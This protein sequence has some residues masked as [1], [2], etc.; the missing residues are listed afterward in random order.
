[1][2]RPLI[3]GEGSSGLT[4][5]DLKRMEQYNLTVAQVYCYLPTT[6]ILDNATL[7]SVQTSMDTLRI[8]GVKA[9]WRFAY[10]R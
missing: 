1:M 9:L 5:D 6:P 7:K 10:D 4:L 2:D 8:A 3:S